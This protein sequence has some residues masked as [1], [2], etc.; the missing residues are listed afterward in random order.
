M[1]SIDCQAKFVEKIKKLFSLWDRRKKRIKKGLG[2]LLFLIKLG[3][4]EMIKR[5]EMVEIAR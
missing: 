4:I 1:H 3:I 2:M 5:I